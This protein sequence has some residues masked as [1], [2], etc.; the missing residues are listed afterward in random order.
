MT[1]SERTD[2]M[3]AA[4]SSSAASTN[5]NRS[6]N[7][8]KKSEPGRKFHPARLAV[9]VLSC[10]LILC[11]AVLGLQKIHSSIITARRMTTVQAKLD[12]V[13]DAKNR[14]A[15][16]DMTEQIT[17]ASFNAL[18]EMAI[19]QLGA[20]EEQIEAL[21]EDGLSEQE[22]D[23]I[24][25]MP[26][27]EELYLNIFDNL[28]RYPQEYIDFLCEDPRRLTFVSAYV[29]QEP[30][31]SAS[32]DLTED[33][34]SVPALVQYD[35]RWAFQPYAGSALGLNGSAPAALSAAA[36][37]LEQNPSLTP[38]TVAA[39]IDENSAALAD[40]TLISAMVP[41]AAASI[42]LA[43]QPVALD[44][45]AFAAQLSS[46]T[47]I[48]G[49][50]PAGVLSFSYQYVLI[51]DSSEDGMVSVHFPAFPADDRD[52]SLEEAV[53]LLAE[54]W[55]LSPADPSAVSLQTL[56]PAEQQSPAPGSSQAQTSAGLN[57]DQAADAVQSAQDDAS[58]SFDGLSEASAENMDSSDLSEQSASEDTSDT[59]IGAE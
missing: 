21:K 50:I 55:S 15:A 12:A 36:A 16:A 13:A 39:A 47:L 19:T 8:K 52:M 43:A 26:S 22:A 32:E 20:F 5:K 29:N 4:R 54:A 33:L 48:L 30:Y 23:S 42:G 59:D 38:D 51:S 25:S 56:Q 14:V 1:V 24:A 49:Y 3:S 37:Y 11:L 40:G 45:A 53:S 57:E 7:T 17:P 41:A 10:V 18:Q 6:V 9:V 34:S 35:L 46:G 44:S 2:R 58:D 27:P 28:A 31:V